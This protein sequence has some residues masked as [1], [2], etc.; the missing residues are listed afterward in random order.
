MG[1]AGGLELWRAAQQ[2]DADRVQRL[3]AKGADPLWPAQDGSCALHVAAAQGHLDCCK[4]LCQHDVRLAEHTDHEGQTPLYLSKL[5]QQPHCSYYLKTIVPELEKP[6]Q[7]LPAP[8]E[9]RP[10][11]YKT[12]GLGCRRV[13]LVIGQAHYKQQQLP[14]AASDAQLLACRLQDLRFEVFLGINLS[15]EELLY[16]FD[17][18]LQNVGPQDFAVVYYTGLACRN[19]YGGEQETVLLGTDRLFHV[20]HEEQLSVERIVSQLLGR[21]ACGGPEPVWEEERGPTLVF[22][23][24][25]LAVKNTTGVEVPRFPHQIAREASASTRGPELEEP[26]VG[27]WD[28]PRGPESPKPEVGSTSVEFGHD[29]HTRLRFDYGRAPTEAKISARSGDPSVVGSPARSINSDFPVWRVPL[30]QNR[31][32]PMSRTPPAIPERDRLTLVEEPGMHPFSVKGRQRAAIVYAHTPSEVIPESLFD[33]QRW[34]EPDSL[35]R[36]QRSQLARLEAEAFDYER[37]PAR[38]Q[39]LEPTDDEPARS[40]THWVL[41]VKNVEFPEAVERDFH[42]RFGGSYRGDTGPPCPRREELPSDAPPP[43]LFASI[44]EEQLGAKLYVEEALL[45]LVAK[46]KE[47]SDR[48]QAPLL[49]LGSHLHTIL[50]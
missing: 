40:S 23:H 35:L 16:Q 12:G 18:F 28:A 21:A 39:Q 11:F 20:A 13:A 38:M 32:V 33:P 47:R 29:S 24:A 46:V 5:H 31:Q 1:A 22:V 9:A 10:N 50:M 3:L 4:V 17:S 7:S 8:F 42:C 15:R 19:T 37:L 41:P 34:Q 6:L 44:V 36:P 48:R 27:P 30:S 25:P 45:S 49:S 43:S 26:S 14:H 2:G